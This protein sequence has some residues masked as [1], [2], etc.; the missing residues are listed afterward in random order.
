MMTKKSIQ[1]FTLL[2][3]LW[4]SSCSLAPL[5]DEKTGSTNGKDKF[6]IDAGYSP[7]LYGKGSYGITDDLDVSV[8]LETQFFFVLS[9][10]LK[11]SLINNKDGFSL[12][13]HGGGF[14]G[15]D[16]V[17]TRGVYGGLVTAYKM[18]WFEPYLAAKYNY[19][20]WGGLNSLDGEERDDLFF[21]FA[22]SATSLSFGYLQAVLGFNFWLDEDVA[23][24]LNGKYLYYDDSAISDNGVFLPGLE[25]L[26]RL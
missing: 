15:S 21:D 10:A 20:K 12:A 3:F 26:I 6:T 22:N 7:F 8:A 14:Y 11:Y 23:L 24:T 4:L 13:T 5:H 1:Y 18:K 16:A 9:A 19:V 2:S 25:I 17:S